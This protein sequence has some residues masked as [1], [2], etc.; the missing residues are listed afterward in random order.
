MPTGRL[1]TPI[2]GDAPT[3][4]YPLLR[5]ILPKPLHPVAR[6]LKRKLKRVPADIKAPYRNVLPYIQ[7]SKARQISIVEKTKALIDRGVP[8]DFV[9][10]G[11]LDGG[12]AALMAHSAR[13]TDR[14]LH[15]MDA[16]RGLPDATVKDGATAARFNG[17]AVGSQRRALSALRDVD[18]DLNNV[19]FHRGWFSETIPECGIESIA[20]LHIDCDFYEPTKLVLNAFF[21]RLS[22]G[23]YVQLDDYTAFEGCRVAVNEFLDAHP[24]IELVVDAG[25]GGA[26]YFQMPDLATFY[27]DTR[28]AG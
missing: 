9:E 5:N 3:Q 14:Q 24:E 22:P 27:Y 7:A 15:L 20:F 21:H 12:T 16:W 25:G 19:T 10:C 4:K 2:H 18:A 26:V 1:E 17:H 8:G 11:V 6:S 28:R 23:A 13:G